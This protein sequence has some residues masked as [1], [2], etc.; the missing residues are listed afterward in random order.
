MSHTFL[1]GHRCSHKAFFELKVVICG[2]A[3]DFVKKRFGYDPPWVEIRNVYREVAG[4]VR[5]D[6]CVWVR[7]TTSM[8]TYQS[9]GIR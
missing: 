4:L 1:H 8:L 7:K 9:G 6:S 5:K 2:A 3:K